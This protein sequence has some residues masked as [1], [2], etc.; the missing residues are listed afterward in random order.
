MERVLTNQGKS[1]SL[2]E[3]AL[4]LLMAIF[5]P[6]GAVDFQQQIVNVSSESIKSTFKNRNVIK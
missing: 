3:R 5:S 6:K 4:H 1:I 2:K